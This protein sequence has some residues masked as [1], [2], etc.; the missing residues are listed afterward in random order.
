VTI[1][2]LVLALALLARVVVVHPESAFR[3]P[4]AEGVLLGLFL[5]AVAGGLVVGMD[6]GASAHSTLLAAR[7]MAFYAAFW[8]VRPLFARRDTRRLTF[9]ALVAVALVVVG[10]QLAQVVLGPSHHLFLAGSSSQEV[11]TI[12]SEGAGSFF[13]VR[14]PGLVL[15][16]VVCAFAI[17]YLLWGPPRRRL[18]AVS[19]A[20]VTFT[21]VVLSLNRNMLLGLALGLCVALLVVPRMGRAAAIL[22]AVA[23]LAI[24][25]GAVLGGAGGGAIVDRAVSI[26]NW[27]QLQ[28]GTLSDRYY[29]NHLAMAQISSHPVAGIGWGTSYGALLAT[30]GGHLTTRYFIHN[31]Y[32][33]IWLRAGLLGIAALVLALLAAFRG[34]VRFARRAGP[35]ESWLGAGIVVSLVALAA[36]A[37]V[38][39]YFMDAD[40]MVPLVSVLAL[41]S[42]L[43]R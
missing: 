35:D 20:L 1:A 22:A 42:A 33:G 18:A 11:Y 32:L 8:L 17:A 12:E 38:G 24:G 40:G 34:G 28:S 43:R 7:D 25:V 26:G 27:S 21:G 5:L 36:S 3:G 6:G 29:E 23:L 39:I 13:R 31:Q 30:H 10:M 4:S 37:T 9:A 16:Y 14:P 41:S 2:E 19:L 15:V